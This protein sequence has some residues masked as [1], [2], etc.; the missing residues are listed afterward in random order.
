MEKKTRGF[1]NSTSKDGSVSLHFSAEIA[2]PLRQIC[3]LLD[4][5]MTD[6][7]GEL[8]L[9]DVERIMN[10]RF[11]EYL[12]LPHDELARRCMEAEKLMEGPLKGE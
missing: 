10:D 11:L 2:A 3:K 1:K 7:A 6:L 5:N 8:L 12:K 4:R 9:N